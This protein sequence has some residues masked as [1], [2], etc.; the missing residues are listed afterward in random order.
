LICLGRGRL[1]AIIRRLLEKERTEREGPRDGGAIRRGIR[2]A[3]GGGGDAGRARPGIEVCASAWLDRNDAPG[4]GRADS[5]SMPW[6]FEGRPT[7][8]VDERGTPLPEEEEE[9]DTGTISE[10]IEDERVD[11]DDGKGANALEGGNDCDAAEAASQD[12]G[13]VKILKG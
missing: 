4:A 6:K 3:A 13:E 2:L 5:L 11:V 8:R 12:P 10:V 9:E 1:Y 7:G